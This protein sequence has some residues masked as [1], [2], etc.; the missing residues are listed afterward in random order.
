MKLIRSEH[1]SEDIVN[2]IQIL[3]KNYAKP[4]SGQEVADP[5]FHTYVCPTEAF[6]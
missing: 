6:V 2:D 5:F 1:F 4:I 3:Q